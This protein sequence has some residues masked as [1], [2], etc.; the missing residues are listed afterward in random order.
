MLLNCHSYYSLRYGTFSIE[1]LLETAA[2]MGHKKVVLTDINNTSAAWS[3]VRL[4]SK[5]GIEPVLGV[6]FRNGVHQKFVAIAK[7]LDGFRE[8]NSFLSPILMN[9]EEVSEDAPKF[10]KAYVIYPFQ[11]KELRPL[12]KNEYIGIKPEQLPLL[13]LSVWKNKTDKLVMLCTASFA[14]KKDFNTHR[15]LRAI[16]L[17]VL[18]SKLPKEEEAHE[19][20]LLRSS[21]EIESLFK[22]YPQIL[23]NTKKVLNDCSIKFTFGVN[24]NKKV[25]G[26]SEATDFKQLK[27]L[28]YEGLKYRYEKVNDVILDRIAKEL[29]IIQQKEFTSYFLI[30]WDIVKYAR[31]RGF[32]YVGR[33]SG[34]N[35]VVA[36]CLRI[37]DVDPI[38]LD[39]YFERFINLYRENPPDFDLDFSWKDRDEVTK[40]I[41]DKYGHQHTA[42]IATYNTFKYRA[43]VRELGKVFGLPKEDMDR[44]SRE[45]RPYHQLDSIEKLVI[46]YSKYIQ[47][48]PNY[49]SIHAGGV[50]ISEKPIATYTAVHLPPKGFPTTMF[51]MVVAEDIGLYKFDILSQR[52]L[53]HIKDAVLAVKKNRNIDLDI[54]DIKK[55]KEDPKIKQLLKNGRTMG[56]FYVESPAMR[57]LLRKLKCDDYLSLVA[58][59]SIIRPGVAQ[60]GMMREYI[61][62]F[63]NP[64][65]RKLAHPI[66]LDI[67]PDTFGVMVYQ[68]DVIKVA[69]YFAGLTLA[70]ADVLRRGMSGK[71]RSREEFQKVKDKF[72]EN[73]NEKGHDEKLSREIWFQI[74]SFAGYSFSKGHSASYAVESF[75]SLYLKAYFPL[76]F[77]VGVINNFGGFYRTETYFHEAKMGGA[78]IEPPC[79]NKSDYVTSIQDKTI[80]LG[81]IHINE[82]EKKSIQKILSSREQNGPFKNLKDFV[83]RTYLSLEQCILLCKIG[84]LRF[85]HKTKKEIMW[86]LHF[87]LSGHNNKAEDKIELFEIPNKDYTL[88]PLYNKPHEDAFDQIELINFSLQNPFQLLKEDFNHAIHANE[89]HK[90][91]GQIITICGYL[92]QVKKVTTSKGNLMYFACLRDY[93]GNF[94]DTTHFPNVARAFPF[95]GKGIYKLTAKVTEE[96]DFYSLEVIQMEKMH[97]IEDPRYG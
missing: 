50:L 63:R 22:D 67:M 80:F 40:Y 42:L 21:E 56:C 13:P 9:K 14:G 5:Y 1:H 36:Y 90:H 95:R 96:F 91:N 31:K 45:N 72:F 84:A 75:Q 41:F 51:D 71:Y 89:F 93:Y 83:K 43:M 55:F 3:F 76:E 58:A 16:G 24:N 38:D 28:T 37:T 18:L 20:D 34:A 30:N 48:F 11:K 86:G 68:E 69:H 78:N 73:C 77:M 70:E 12:R 81:F 8:I 60:S 27:K 52:G 6:D 62:R 74:E 59:S 47:G 64:E 39:L 94:F 46:K 87:L 49:L 57:M 32:F 10:E 54:H 23:L 17:N 29:N 66:M 88:P 85:T 79:V 25:F 26:E 2:E 19:T 35:S 44:L 65:R 4:A 97:T 61:L 92:V 82:L 53:G 33:G 15:L 7:N